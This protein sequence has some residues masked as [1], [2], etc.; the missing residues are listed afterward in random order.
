MKDTTSNTKYF[1]GFITNMN[2][3]KQ[4]EY[5]ETN[6]DTTV[7]TKKPRTIATKNQPLTQTKLN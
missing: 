3:I 7:K 2:K 6:H 5:F 4:I 1:Y